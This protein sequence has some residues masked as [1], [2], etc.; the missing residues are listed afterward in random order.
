M[1]TTA[2]N[3]GNLFRQLG[4]S[5]ESTDVDRFIAEHPLPSGVALAQA[6]FW[7]AEQAAFLKQAIDDDSDWSE[8]A[9]ELAVRLS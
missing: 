7:N 2:H 1:E 6:P 4:L 3:L 8:A 5:G 9:D